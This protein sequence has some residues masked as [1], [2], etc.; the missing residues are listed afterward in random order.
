M[1]DTELLD[2]SL[3]ALHDNAARLAA[4]M[5]REARFYANA[6]GWTHHRRLIGMGWNPAIASGARII[7]IAV[8]EILP[9]DMW[10]PCEGG[11]TMLTIAVVEDDTV[12]DIVAFD[13]AQPGQWFMRKGAAWALGLDEIETVCGTFEGEAVI[14]LHATPFDW[15]RTDMAGVCVLEWTDQARATIRDLHHIQVR[16]QRYAQALRLELSRAPRLPEIT[17]QGQSRRAA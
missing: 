3:E 15:L 4:P 17:Y 1:N 2:V 5:A 10:Q 9:N 12:I 6:F 13:P 7:G 11:T 8:V 14:E 16:D